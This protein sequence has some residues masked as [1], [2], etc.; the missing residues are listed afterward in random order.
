M[1][2]MMCNLARVDSHDL[3]KGLLTQADTDSLWEAGQQISACP[4]TI[5]DNSRQTILHVGAQARRLK[6][7][8]GLAAVFIDYLQLLDPSERRTKRY[9]EVG[10]ISRRLKALAKEL[11][12]P[13]VCMAQL[14][15][16]PEGRQDKEPRLADLRESGSL[17]MDA[18]TVLL[19]HRPEDKEGVVK[20]GVVEVN[21]AK[22]R[23]GPVGKV[24]LAFLPQYTRFEDHAAGFPPC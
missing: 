22:Q 1:G 5:D 16:G 6:R 11:D 18:D 3:R 15:R 13:L 21:V 12:V 8:K 19:L 17:E 14:N 7:R 10:D 20:E 4:L 24:T 2:R 23:N 9:E